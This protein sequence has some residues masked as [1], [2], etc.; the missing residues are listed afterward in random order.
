MKMKKKPK[1]TPLFGK[2]LYCVCKQGANNPKPKPS[3]SDEISMDEVTNE[4]AQN[5]VSKMKLKKHSNLKKVMALMTKVIGKYFLSMNLGCYCTK[6]KLVLKMLTYIH[7]QHMLGLH[8]K[9]IATRRALMY[10]K[11]FTR[12]VLKYIKAIQRQS[13]PKGDDF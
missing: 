4:I 9:K 6:N 5:A 12:N 13:K 1:Y 2:G 8:Y 10:R 3:K 11:I 7:K